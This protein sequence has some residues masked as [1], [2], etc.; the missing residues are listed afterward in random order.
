MRTLDYLV[1]LALLLAAVKQTAQIYGTQDMLQNRYLP[2]NIFLQDT[3][4]SRFR[5]RL[6]SNFEK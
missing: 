1:R 5:S 6:F 2:N 3:Q 4:T